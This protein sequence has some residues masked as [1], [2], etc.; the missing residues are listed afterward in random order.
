[1]NYFLI[2]D[3]HEIKFFI[4]H[5]NFI[6]NRTP[7]EYNGVL[8]KCKL[9]QFFSGLSGKLQRTSK[10]ALVVRVRTNTGLAIRNMF[11]PHQRCVALLGQEA[12]SH[13]G[14]C[15]ADATI[16]LRLWR[17]LT[18]KPDH[19][20]GREYANPVSTTLL[21]RTQPAGSDLV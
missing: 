9:T 20:I 11:R 13:H 17:R 14:T 8:E 10:C 4:M 1:M 16:H 19:E 21:A 15:H 7:W 3:F 18:Q 6:S 2:K 5:F 12:P